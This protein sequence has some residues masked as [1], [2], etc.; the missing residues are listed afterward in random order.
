MDIQKYT[1]PCCGYRTLE[2]KPPDTYQICPICFWEDDAYQIEFLGETG[3]NN[4][5]LRSAQEN[6]KKFGACE[7]GVLSYVRKPIKEDIY[8][9][10]LDISD[11]VD[12]P[13][14]EMIK[15]F[16]TLDLPLYKLVDLYCKNIV[17]PNS[18]LMFNEEDLSKYIT[19]K[20]LLEYYK[21]SNWSMIKELYNDSD[22]IEEELKEVIDLNKE[23]VKIKLNQI[24]ERFIDTLNNKNS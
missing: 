22:D 15:L 18:R 21:I 14:D 3:A 12:V 17:V 19:K 8:D 5:S 13:L 9:G 23:Q 4:V 7:K 11:I 24:R 6:F 10:P 16:K 2:S 1:C 20:D